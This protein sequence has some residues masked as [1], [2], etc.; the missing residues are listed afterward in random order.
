MMKR[1]LWILILLLFATSAWSQADAVTESVDE[2]ASLKVEVAHL[3]VALLSQRLET[4]RA[5]A[6]W[7]DRE[8]ILMAVEERL[9]I[10]DRARVAS[11]I[12]ESLGCSNGYDLTALTCVSGEME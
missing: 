11:E 3:K 12:A 10:D 9:L 1:K 7:L 2:I 6:T 8:Q 4:L 5:K